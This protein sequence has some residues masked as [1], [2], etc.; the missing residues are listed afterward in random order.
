MMRVYGRVPVDPLYPNGP[1]VWKVVTTDPQGFN[2][3]VYV[4]AMAQTYKLNLAES[5]FWANYGIPAH[6][7]VMQQIFP[8]YYVIF[9][10]QFYSQFFAL[11]SVVQ[12]PSTEPSYRVDAITH[13][14]VKLRYGMQG[15][16]I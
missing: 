8:T 3:A 2:D 1:K 15:A 9:I 16:P 10:Q 4:T 12:L 11:L 7:S 6:E 5:P 13:A 14:G